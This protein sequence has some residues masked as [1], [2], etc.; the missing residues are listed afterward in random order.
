MDPK[1]NTNLLLAVFGGTV[2]LSAFLLFQVQPLVSKAILPWFGG[3]P[4]VWTTCMLFFQVLLFGGYLYAHLSEHVFG[5][6]A[7]YLVHIVLIGLAL[8]TLPVTPHGFWKPVDSEQPVARILALLAVSVGLPYFVLASTGPLVQAWFSRMWRGRSPYRLY[9][10]SNVGSLAALVSYPIVVEPLWNVERQGRYWSL[11]FVVFG[12]ACGYAAL[13]MLRRDAL[14]S[15]SEPDVMTGAGAS[16]EIATGVQGQ[17]GIGLPLLW[18]AL[19]AIASWMLLATTNHVCQDMA[20]VPL[21]WVLP[22]GLYLASFIIC[23]D[24]PRWYWRPG[25]ALATLGLTL[26]VADIGHW[27]LSKWHA[28]T[29]AEQITAKFALLFVV[30]MTCHGELARLRP[31]PRHLTYYYLMIAAGGA[32]GGVLVSAVAPLVFVTYLEWPIGLVTGFAVAMAVLLVDRRLWS[33]RTLYAGAVVLAGGLTCIAGVVHLQAETGRS[34][35]AHMRNF[36]GAL[37]VS[38]YDARKPE[39]HRRALIHG[40]IV[41]GIQFHA[42]KLHRLPTTYYHRDTGVGQAIRFYR[43]LN[44]VRIGVVGLGTATMA[45]YVREQDRIRF[46]EINPLVEKA[47]HE[48]FTYLDDC[49]GQVEVVIGDARLSLEREPPQRFHV[50]VLDAFS[51]DAIPAHL[52]TL[53]AFRVYVRHMDPEGAIAVHVSNLYLDLERVVHAISRQI[54]WNY[55]QVTTRDDDDRMHYATDWVLVSRNRDLLRSVAESAGA[56]DELPDEKGVL[57]TDDFSN[58]LG[59]LK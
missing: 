32:V 29:F 43:R 38:E 27:P 54:E 3:S 8:A 47:A 55:V 57:W 21:L 35:L 2:L 59:I 49:P 17:L 18:A 44:S 48:Y 53:E 22:L 50:L 37:R 26:F 15:A 34:G 11:G 7:R 41:H 16:G 31:D 13:R 9:A 5:R 40:N 25:C 23:F 51:G 42:P 20:V 14:L 33:E 1:P 4:A 36:Y 45:A 39:R 56:R 12:I 24:H 6:R 58:L 30:C 19:P 52:L 10:L 28:F 46:Y